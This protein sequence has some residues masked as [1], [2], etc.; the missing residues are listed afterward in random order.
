MFATLVVLGRFL[1]RFLL[2]FKNS[3]MLPG[4]GRRCTFGVSFL[5][6]LLTA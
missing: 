4:D 5:R 3:A 2:Q 6:D 1:L